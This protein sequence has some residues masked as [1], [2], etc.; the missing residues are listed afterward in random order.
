MDIHSSWSRNFRREYAE[1]ID[2]VSS[3]TVI[4]EFH[5]EGPYDFKLMSTIAKNTNDFIFVF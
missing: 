5:P 1:F 3:S 2:D 4:P